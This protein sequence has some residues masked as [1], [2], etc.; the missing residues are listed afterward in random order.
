MDELLAL[1]ITQTTHIRAHVHVPYLSTLEYSTLHS[2]IAGIYVV[3]F[4]NDS[5]SCPLSGESGLNFQQY[6]YSMGIQI[7]LLGHLLLLELQAV[8]I[9]V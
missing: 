5:P 4:S 8:P 6:P 3:S 2:R 7:I 9:V 1:I